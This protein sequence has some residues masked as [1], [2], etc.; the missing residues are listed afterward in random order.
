[1][2]AQFAIDVERRLVVTTFAGENS[3]EEIIG[4]ASKIQSHPDFDPS[5]S[6]IIDCRAISTV[7]ISTAGVGRIAR[8]KNIF[9]PASL[10]VIVA[11]QDHIFGLARMGQALADQ[12][13]P[14]IVVVRTMEE[15][16]KLLNLQ[17]SGTE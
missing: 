2:S 12:T 4:L 6:E 11:P 10:H 9:D 8:R 17:K 16:Y 7:G 5:F 1:V 15:A 13:V 3:E 14:N